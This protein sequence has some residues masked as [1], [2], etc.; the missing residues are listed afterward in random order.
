[1]HMMELLRSVYFHLQCKKTS[2][3]PKSSVLAKWVMMRLPCRAGGPW[4]VDGAVL[5]L[6]RDIRRTS[7]APLMDTAIVR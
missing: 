5:C 6:Y 7:M 1:M 2:S 4:I 3:S